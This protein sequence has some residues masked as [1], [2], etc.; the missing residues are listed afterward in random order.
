MLRRL[1]TDEFVS[2]DTVAFEVADRFGEMFVEINRNGNPA[3]TKPILKAFEQL[4][5]ERVVW[6]FSTRLWRFRQ[7]CDEPG[8]RQR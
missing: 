6:E 1:E 3:V 2:Q 5:G 7:D 4:T 8:R